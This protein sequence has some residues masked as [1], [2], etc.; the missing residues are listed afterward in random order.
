MFSELL[1]SFLKVQV[2]I[3]SES[4]ARPFFHQPRVKFFKLEKRDFYSNIPR[5]LKKEKKSSE[6]RNGPMGVFVQQN[7][8]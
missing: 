6:E 3:L 4:S 5:K 7:S 1:L 8:R 2:I